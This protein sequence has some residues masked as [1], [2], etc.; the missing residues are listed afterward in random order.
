MGCPDWPKCFGYFIPPYEESE[1]LF[2]PNYD[3]KVNQM[4]IV[5]SEKLYTANLDFKS[6]KNI[7]F[8]NWSSYEKHDYVT[9]DP[10]H[11][12]IEFINRL[13]GAVAG[14]FTIIMLI[15]SLKYWKVKKI[16]PLISILIVLGMGF[17]AWLGKLVVDSN[18]AP[19][20]ITVH[21]L[22]ALVIVA[23]IIYLIYYSKEKK[24]Y[25]YDKKIKYLILFSIA[26][27][28]IQVISGTQVREFIDVQYELS[29]NKE[30][31]LQSPDFFFYFHRRIQNRY[32]G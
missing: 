14:I 13:I 11:T 7:D 1:L 12:W 8:N 22:M 4:I 29:K 30:L 21:M 24:D 23:L 6:G 16:I 27:T 18:L 5:N 31:W 17:Q 20:K 28:L 3:Y 19:Y 26:L 32:S 25:Q 9:Y 10:V 15:L 2:K